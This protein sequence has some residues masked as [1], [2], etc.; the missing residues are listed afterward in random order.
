MIETKLGEGILDSSE[1]GLEL[2]PVACKLLKSDS[3]MRQKVE[4]KYRKAELKKK[5]NRQGQKGLSA[6]DE[7]NEKSVKVGK[8]H[9]IV[10]CTQKL[11]ACFETLFYRRSAK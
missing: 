9:T 4:E 10:L 1:E 8:K 5:R 6:K 11:F 7:A 3:E 2:I